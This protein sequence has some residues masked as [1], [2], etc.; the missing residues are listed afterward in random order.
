[1]PRVCARLLFWP[2][3][4]WNA[5]LGRVLGVRHWWDRVD[6]H[7]LL[8][9]MPLKRDV[10]KLVREGVRAVV[11]MCEEYPGPLAEYKQAGIEQ[12]W[13]PT[14]DFNPPTLEQVQQAV[15][16]MQRFV[17]DGQGVYVH[18]KAGRARS[19]TIVLCWL[20]KARGFAPQDAQDWL[21]ARRAHVSPN[22]LRRKV[23]HEFLESIHSQ[24]SS[25]Q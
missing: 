8:G 18:C 3:F 23:V 7:V 24:T 16:F 14:V 17:A 2:T 10:P 5:L 22:L 21:L 11:N 9:A 19:A 12:L 1:M 25:A 6:E 4:L 20:I 15:A 13:V